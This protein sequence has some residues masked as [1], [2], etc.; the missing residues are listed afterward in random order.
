[1]DYFETEEVLYSLRFDLVVVVEKNSFQNKCRVRVSMQ[2]L[3]IRLS[4][5]FF[6][7]LKYG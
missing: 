1:M 2:N 5:L 7:W 6:Y 3:L 4:I